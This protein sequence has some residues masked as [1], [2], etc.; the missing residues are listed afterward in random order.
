[1]HFWGKLEKKRETQ[2]LIKLYYRQRKESSHQKLV[3]E[4][5]HQLSA[6]FKPDISMIKNRI[7]DLIE[8]E[9]LE[10]IHGP[11]IDSYRYLA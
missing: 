5:L 6:Q 2:V 9:Y 7:E 11:G 10:R 8:R 4:T 1:L 3:L